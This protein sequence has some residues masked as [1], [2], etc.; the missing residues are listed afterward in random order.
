MDNFN[1]LLIIGLWIVFTW[2]PVSAV[3]VSSLPSGLMRTKTKIDTVRAMWTLVVTFP[4]D[5][6]ADTTDLHVALVQAQSELSFWPV[7]SGYVAV[8][9]FWVNRILELQEELKYGP[10]G[11]RIGVLQPAD[12]VRGPTDRHK[13]SVRKAQGG[14]HAEP[15]DVTVGPTS[16]SSKRR[17]TGIANPWMLPPRV[18]PTLFSQRREL[19]AM[20]M[21]MDVPTL[22]GPSRWRHSSAGPASHPRQ[23][24]QRTRRGLLPFLGDVG[25]SL[26]G[27]A[28]E[29]D[30]VKLQDAL[31]DN[32]KYVDAVR[33]DQERLVSIVNVTRAESVR[34]ARVLRAMKTVVT[35]LGARV[36]RLV[37]DSNTKVAYNTEFDRI[38]AQVSLL[39]R[40]VRKVWQRRQQYQAARRDLE[41][42][43]LSELLL[44]IDNLEGLAESKLPRGTRFVRPLIWYYSKADV[45]MTSVQG[46]LIYVV[47]L[48]LVDETDHQAISLVSYPVPNVR[49]NV[50]VELDVD[51]LIALN[52][53]TGQ[54]VGLDPSLCMGRD[55]MVCVPGPTP[56]HTQERLSCVNAV[57]VEKDVRKYCSARVVARSGDT[58]HYH[59]MNDYVLTT[60][61]TTLREQCDWD[62]PIKLEPGV[63]RVRWAGECSV[64]T[65]EYCIPSTIQLHSTY[66]L[67]KW[68][69]LNVTDLSLPSLK[70]Q[71]LE[72][73]P[74]IPD[75]G[76]VK[77]IRLDDLLTATAPPPFAWSHH[78]TSIATDVSVGFV[79]I[80]AVAVGIFICIRKFG[81]SGMARLFRRN[82]PLS[83][84]RRPDGQ[85]QE[86]RIRYRASKRT[87]EV[88]C[89][90]PEPEAVIEPV[91]PQVPPPY[92]PDRG[93]Q[94]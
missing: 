41:S 85:S 45:R 74:D 81:V 8:R 53:V 43:S 64:C 17:L 92:F 88:S 52:P 51:G 12:D 58:F 28:T 30:L 36:R 22:G 11:P 7:P 82:K 75:P 73:L 72:G 1:G 16:S 25:K 49:R 78:H 18:T 40:Q 77:T 91:Y 27:L 23:V 93:A 37:N 4:E 56:R 66:H 44:P 57:F 59:S 10:A 65:P 70:V 55:P 19:G 38:S 24:L 62:H 32:R 13:R 29:K 6:P 5:D 21:T 80:V 87:R 89:H 26:F 90:E 47:R 61:G 48:P 79:V 83:L 39:S 76:D 60:W 42:G 14:Y 94:P 31:E 33:H 2:S 71:D 50:T 15:E 84:G 68:E 54:T 20:S 69:P 3:E 67:R 9:A 35:E 86:L 63:Y 34:N 46:D